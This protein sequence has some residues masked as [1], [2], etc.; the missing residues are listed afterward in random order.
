MYY[1]DY[2]YLNVNGYKRIPSSFFNNAC[3]NIAFNNINIVRGNGH[4][5]A[6]ISKCTVNNKTYTIS[7]I[8]SSR[9]QRRQRDGRQTR[10]KRENHGFSLVRWFANNLPNL[11]TMPRVVAAPYGNT[12][13][14]KDPWHEAVTAH[15][16]KR[17]SHLFSTHT[18]AYTRN[19]DP[20][21]AIAYARVAEAK[22][23]SSRRCCRWQDH[24]RFA[25]AR[26][27][28]SWRDHDVI[29]VF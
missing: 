5:L 16:R 21:R 22:T 26:F 2:G 9:V 10:R 28:V 15:P 24:F 25:F 4:L 29:D 12:A 1:T 7:L 18:T 13:C 8:Q 20:A 3:V 14:S 17:V 6:C 27:P 11:S 23:R 19:P